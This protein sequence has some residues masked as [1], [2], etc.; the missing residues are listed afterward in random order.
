MQLFII[1]DRVWYTPY[2]LHPSPSPL[3][4]HQ[5]NMLILKQQNKGNLMDTFTWYLW[6]TLQKATK[7]FPPSLLAGHSF[8]SPFCKLKPAVS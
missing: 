1:E 5:E 4:L 7:K 3:S 8:K 2:K 6:H